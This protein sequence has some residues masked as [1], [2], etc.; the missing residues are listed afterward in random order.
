[1]LGSFSKVIEKV[2]Y[3]LQNHLNKYSILAE[4]FGF[5]ADSSTGKAIYKL[6]KETLQALNSKSAVGGICFD[7][8]KAFDCLNYNFMVLIAKLNHGLNH[9]LITDIGE[10]RFWTN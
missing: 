7:L 3:K 6:I 8:E 5:R 4:H 9:I 10:F 1:M 2:M